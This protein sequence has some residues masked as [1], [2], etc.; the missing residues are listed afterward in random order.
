M[1]DV[2]HLPH[3]DARGQEALRWRGKPVVGY[4]VYAADDRAQAKGYAHL[5]LLTRL[6]P[7][8]R[9]A[10]QRNASDRPPAA[11]ER[12]RRRRPPGLC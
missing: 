9:R 4:E 8:S 7:D 3:E 11:A 2:H 10:E 6:P 5:T 1:G 12:T